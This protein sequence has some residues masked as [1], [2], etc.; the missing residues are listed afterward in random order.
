MDGI[1]ILDKPSGLTSQQALSR[2]RRALKIK[3]L[4]HT[5]T[6]DPLATGVLPVALGEATKIIPYLEE[7]TKVYRVTGRLGESTDSYDSDGTILRRADPTWVDRDRLREVLQLFLGPQEQV[8]PAYSAIKVQ[9]RPLYDYARSGEEVELRPRQVHFIDLDLESFASPE[10]VL[11]VKCSKG[12]YIR[13]LIHDIG[14]RLEC[15]AHVTALRRLASGGFDLS[16]ALGLEQILENPE[17][18]ASHLLSIERL[19]ADWPK[20]ELETSEL[21]RVRAGVPLRRIQQWIEKGEPPSRRLVLVHASTI[22]A[23]IE[24]IPGGDFKYLRVFNREDGSPA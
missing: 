15:G 12:T 4:G 18:A 14:E 17:Q 11:R 8:P 20:V 13:S 16:E 23:L 3:K 7:S 24:S 9:G 19:L 10:F 1:L 5:G 21:D 2:V 6:L 22:H